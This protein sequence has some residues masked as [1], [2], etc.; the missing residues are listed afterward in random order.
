MN[1]V[2]FLS[3]FYYLILAFIAGIAVFGFFN[4]K[5]K[6]MEQ[7]SLFL[8]EILLVGNVLL[9]GEL[10]FFSLTPFYRGFNLW[11]LISL[12]VFWLLRP[13]TREYLN[14]FLARCRGISF[15]PAFLVFIVFLTI[16]TF[17]NCFPLMD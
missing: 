4:A 16:F 9:A 12:N 14:L 10:M 3:F 6:L 15:D 11:I 5:D 17:R 8:G 13:K 2:I 1:Y 7:R